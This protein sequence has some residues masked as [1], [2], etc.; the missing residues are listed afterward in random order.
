M[1]KSNFITVATLTLLFV[2]VFIASSIFTSSIQTT[3][4][5]F[6]S[7]SPGGRTNSFGDVSN[8]AACHS[9]TLNSGSAIVSIS[10]PQL[11]NGYVP[12]QTYTVDVSINNT[13]S[14][15][16][17][18]ELTAEKDADNS[19]IGTF[20]LVNSMETQFTNS[21]LAVTHNAAGTVVSSN[22][23]TWS[24]NWIAPAT[25]EGN[26]TFYAAFNEAN[27]NGTTTGD[28]IYTTS[29]NITENSTSVKELNQQTLVNVYPNPTKNHIYIKT[30]ETIK[31]LE[32]FNIN[33]ELIT[34]Q[35]G[36]SEELAVSAIK[37]G[38]YFLKIRTNNQ[39]ITKKIIKN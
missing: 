37:Q 38:I 3:A 5:A 14:S 2:V 29:L 7:G 36:N 31:S 11:V 24:F 15:K 30:N 6:T 27:A 17:G 21:N 34:E 8:C 9:G 10:S 25:S 19:K 22:A 35:Q 1:K 12:G 13:S 28:K 4:Y 20:L 33:G 18:F 23:K 32:L 26:I 16:V 39:S